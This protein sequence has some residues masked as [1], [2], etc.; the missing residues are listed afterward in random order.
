ML[1]IASI[2][3]VLAVP[4]FQDTI[5]RQ[6]LSAASSDLY[7]S[8]A[9]TRNEAIRRGGRVDLKAISDNWNNGWE[10][11]IPTGDNTSEQIY[12]HGPVPTGIAIAVPDFGTS[13]SYNGTGRTRTD[14]NSQVPATGV[15]IIKVNRAGSPHKR[16]LQINTIGRPLLC[17]PAV[18][19]TCV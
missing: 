18:D 19:T 15:W 1:A 8:V 5:E 9:M 7:A 6:K 16:L 17:N 3:T 11:T 4:S 13:L 10:I 12:T 14:D 2:I